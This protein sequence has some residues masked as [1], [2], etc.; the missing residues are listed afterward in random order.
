MWMAAKADSWLHTWDVN[1]GQLHPS[2]C[3]PVTAVLRQLLGLCCQLGAVCASRWV[4]QGAA[5]AAG[6]QEMPLVAVQSWGCSW[7]AA[8][9]SVPGEVQHQSSTWAHPGTLSTKATWLG[10]QCHLE[11]TC[12]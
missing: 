4:V 1:S 3:S 5:R 8:W 12:P 7:A 11:S 9:C 2:V 10:S 6:S